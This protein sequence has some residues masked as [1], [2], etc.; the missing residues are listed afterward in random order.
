MFESAVAALDIL[1][2]YLCSQGTEESE[3]RLSALKMKL[4]HVKGASEH[5]T[6][7]TDYSNAHT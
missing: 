3:K 5:Q 6:K 7:I 4:V 2:R 1:S